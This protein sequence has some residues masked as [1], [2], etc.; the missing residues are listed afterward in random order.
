MKSNAGGGCAKTHA[1]QRDVAAP[2]YRAGAVGFM[3]VE[4]GIGPEG[5]TAA[6]HVA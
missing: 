1:D 5:M 3:Q 6:R 2:A 4:K